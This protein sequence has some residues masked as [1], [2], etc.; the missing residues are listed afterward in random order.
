[1]LSREYRLAVRMYQTFNVAGVL[2]PSNSYWTTSG[3]IVPHSNGG[4][5]VDCHINSSVYID[6]NSLRC[7]HLE[8][9]EP[10][11]RQKGRRVHKVRV[12]EFVSRVVRAH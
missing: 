6:A 5:S 7:D 10:H 8:R 3:I 9:S 11:Q 12:D 2:R 4:G 1:M